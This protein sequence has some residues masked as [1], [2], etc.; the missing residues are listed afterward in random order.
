MN[1]EN[2]LEAEEWIQGFL[3]KDPDCEFY[4]LPAWVLAHKRCARV[5]VD[6][7]CT[8]AVYRKDTPFCFSCMQII[9]EGDTL[10]GSDRRRPKTSSL[11]WS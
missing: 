3:N 6:G 4:M 1:Q 2:K 7:Q 8:E 11:F 9:T 10:Y 5:N